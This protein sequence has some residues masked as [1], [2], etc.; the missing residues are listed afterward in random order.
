MLDDMALAAVA[1]S[2]V[3]PEMTV[4][5]AGLAP[6]EFEIESWGTR[7]VTVVLWNELKGLLVKDALELDP[8]D[9]FHPTLAVWL[10]ARLGATETV[11]D[12]CVVPSV[13]SG[14]VEVV[15]ETFCAMFV[16]APKVVTVSTIARLLEKLDV[17]CNRLLLE[18][19]RMLPVITVADE[20]ETT[21]TLVIA[22]TAELKVEAAPLVGIP[23][24]EV[25]DMLEMVELTAELY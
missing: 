22:A 16:D 18:A 4:Y 17:L 25:V 10:V 15:I 3:R 6:D 23:A 9:T 12:P 7:V 8:D 5:K 20:L 1:R 11:D 14:A 2:E 19:I 24:D 21:E 13:A